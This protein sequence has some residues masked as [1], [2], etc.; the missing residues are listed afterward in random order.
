MLM[1]G[2]PGMIK[3][4]QDAVGMFCDV[5]A[6]QTPDEALR[7]IRERVFDA[8]ISTTDQ[9]LPLTTSAGH[10]EAVSIL[11]LIG[12]GVCT[13][14][15][16]GNLH[17]SNPKF[18][19]YPPQAIETIRQAATEMCRELAADR[20]PPD[21]PRQRHRSISIDSTLHFDLTASPIFDPGGQVSRAVVVAWDVTPTRRLHEKLNAI[22]AAGC[23]LLRIDPDALA[24]MDVG[25][26]LGMLEKKIVRCSHDLLHF[27]H[28]AVRVLDNK[29]NRL[30][31]LLAEG[32]SETARNRQ[33]YATTEGNGIS[34]WVAAKGRSYICPD[35][36]RD[37]HVLPG[38]TDAR[39][40]LTVALWLKDRVVGTFNVESKEIAA[41]TEDD[42]QFA[43]IFGRYIA[44][45]LNTLR[46]LAVERH[47]AT[48]QVTADVLA[49]LAAPLNDIVSQASALMEDYIGH[50]DLRR[51][52]HGIIDAVENI[53][54][55][56]RNMEEP[57]GLDGVANESEETDPLLANKRVLVADDEDVIR[58]TVAAVLT[59]AGA[60]VAMAND[61]EDAIR[62]IREQQFDLIISDI[63]MPHRNGYEVFAAAKEANAECHV[64]LMT[65]FGYDPDHA[66]VRASH[67]GLSGVLFKPFKV[68]SL[69]EEARKALSGKSRN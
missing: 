9:F 42:R 20:P 44:I 23:E 53:K 25:E 38:I 31:L 67:E 11:S 6:V 7:A 52:M 5:S 69:L 46:L 54:Q 43:E 21:K 49:E 8:V 36:R 19:S 50:D 66:I 41:F 26:R 12:H 30:D 39:S 47:T 40:S 4:L 2:R 24:D 14:D 16:G 28:F 18:Q 68:D 3:E 57:A 58:D 37:P 22:D 33:L 15:H 63:K 62:L 65:G 48:G 59:R 64:V 35:I 27:Q 60:I 13:V 51:G 17:W 29:T 32:M 1:L 34:G 61:G 10:A 56:I 45:A 55:R